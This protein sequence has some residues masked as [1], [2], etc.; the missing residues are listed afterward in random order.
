MMSDGAKAH[1]HYASNRRGDCADDSDRAYCF[2]WARKWASH[3][4]SG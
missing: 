1:L 4:I 3:V 2:L